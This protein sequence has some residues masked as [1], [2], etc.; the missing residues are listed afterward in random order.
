MLLPAGYSPMAVPSFDGMARL[1][2]VHGLRYRENGATIFCDN[3]R[4]LILRG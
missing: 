4:V 1:V 3:N 2:R